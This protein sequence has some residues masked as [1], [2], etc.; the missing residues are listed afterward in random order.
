MIKRFVF[1]IILVFLIF[2]CMTN[3]KNTKTGDSKAIKIQKK[4]LPPGEAPAGFE[5]KYVEESKSWFLLPNNWY[6]QEEKKDNTIAVFITKEKINPEFTTGI[7]INIYPK[8]QTSAEEYAKNFHAEFIK[9]GTLLDVSKQDTGHFL[10]YRSII[11]S[12]IE[13]E[14]LR[15]FLLT[16]INPRSNT[17][18]IVLYETPDKEWDTNWP[19]AKTVL[20]ILGFNDAF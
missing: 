12:K 7:T 9:Q 8:L 20:S 19:I 18:Y 17:L 10:M 6:Y 16:F 3:E 13:D 5:W 4:T 1:I 11:K 15:L 14:F 2:S